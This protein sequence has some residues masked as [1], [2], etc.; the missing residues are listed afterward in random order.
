MDWIGF[1]TL[2]TAIACLQ[3]VL[4]RGAE[5]DWFELTM[6]CTAAAVAGVAF[7][8]FLWKSLAGGG[9][10]IF[11]LTVL[12]DRNLAASCIIMLCTGFGVFGTGLLL[13]LFLETQ[14]GLPAMNAGLYLMPRSIMT[15][16]CMGLVGRYAHHFSPRS[17][18]FIGMLSLLMSA[19]AFTVVTPQVSV[20]ITWLPNILGGIGAGLLFVSRRRS[21]SPPC[22]VI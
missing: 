7:L 6:I 14:L 9:H 5:K 21:P 10:P 20:S 18:I 17:I 13:P 8:G 11:D 3:L 4:D 16:I 22:H 15:I 1:A 2:A 12:K 19:L